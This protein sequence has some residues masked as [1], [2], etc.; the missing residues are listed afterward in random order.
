MNVDRREAFQ[1]AQSA[2]ADGRPRDAIAPLWALVDRSHLGANELGEC[3][4]LMRQAFAQAGLSRA[5]CTVA[6]YLAQHDVALELAGDDDVDLARCWVLR[7]NRQRAA[8]HFEKGGK[9]GQ[10][11]I[12]LELAGE[13]RAARVLWE[14][15]SQDVRLASDP[16]TQGLVRFNL[17]RACERQG[18]HGAARRAMVESMH[19]LEAA[20]DRFE[21]QGLRER[22][23]DCFQVLIAAGKE[24]AFENLAEGYL[25]CIRILMQDNLRYYVL[26]YY[27]D[28]QS[29]AIERKEFHAAATLF[30][31][32]A[33]FA[34]AQGMPYDTHYRFRAAETHVLA[35]KTTIESGG[36]VEL[37]ENAYASAIDAFNQVSMYSRVR[38]VYGELAQLALPDKRV[39]RYKRLEERL[40]PVPDEA[41]ALVSFPDYLRMDTAYPEI[42]KLDVLEWE[43]EGD[44]AET[45]GDVM[46]DTKLPDFTRRRALVCR[47]Y[48]QSNEH[49]T[50]TVLGGLATHL[51]RVEIYA[52][53]APLERLSLHDAVEVRAACMRA[54]RQMAFKRAFVLVMRGLADGA[55]EV[56]KEALAA[57][58][59]LHFPHAFDPLA[60]IFRNAEEP[61]VRIAAL[62]SIGK[63]PTIEATELLIEVL[64]QGDPRERE[65]AGVLLTRT[66]H[67]EASA[68]LRRAAAN[69]TGGLRQAFDNVLR[70]RGAR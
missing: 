21:A 25:N 5:A 19:L 42:W 69:E 14:R 63:I 15:L 60:R 35:A 62:E 22:A 55:A 8:R 27:E 13:D 34:R 30:R 47:L 49:M 40:G 56:R 65:L 20:A 58:S 44:A 67:P 70:A 6:L 64:R 66:E 52:A 4:R 18:D 48:Q 23:F 36:A 54:T 43:H 33:E 59:L 68:L 61:A 28:F 39:A 37:A 7:G 51:G 17:S 32:C 2:L 45:M 53:L 26:Q 1:R 12:Q 16:Y 11:A 46:L 24:G 29:L 10:A 38:G 3:L 31:E 57:V 41:P 50:A 9:L